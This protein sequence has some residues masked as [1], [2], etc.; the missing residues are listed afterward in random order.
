MVF[1][2]NRRRF[3]LGS[4]A[5]TAGCAIERDPT[6]PP[7]VIPEAL[8]ETPAGQPDAVT[9]SDDWWVNFNSPKLNALVER[10][11]LANLELRAAQSEARALYNSAL[12]VSGSSGIDS[13]ASLSLPVGT[14]ISTATAT[15]RATANVLPFREMSRARRR[16]WLQATSG[17]VEVER[18][19]DTSSVEV[20]RLAV[21]IDYLLRT[22]VVISNSVTN[23]RAAV[24]A[25][26]EQ[27]DRGDSTQLDV[28]RARARLSSVLAEDASNQSDLLTAGARLAASISGNINETLITD[29][30]SGTQISLPQ[31]G[32]GASINI[33][34]LTT[35]PSV[36]QREI[37]YLIRLS[38]LDSA[39]A[40][41][42]PSL[43]V[44]GQVTAST[45]T[46]GWIFSPSLTLPPLSST[47]R[48]ARTDGALD[49]VYAAMFSWQ[50]AV[51]EAATTVEVA[52]IQVQ[53]AWLRVAR[54]DAAARSLQRA[55]V[56]VQSL[57]N[58]GDVTILA[59]LETEQEY[60]DARISY[61]RSRRDLLTSYV[62]L[63]SSV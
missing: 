22:S 60:F 49:R 50:D 8:S 5:L 10:A 18:L 43:S 34:V 58:S 3:L 30:L 23:N 42:F 51:L 57:A 39:R 56:E 40:S 63:F 17:T 46:V 35:K 61:E 16:A 26:E 44:S 62:S 9:A 1:H 6:T 13:S 31:D 20:C 2:F 48:Q 37:T 32:D 4:V 14:S 47:R 52:Q 38:E 11:L 55:L 21:E 53:N 36:V 33:E 19:A 25:L 45:N 24:N 12:D 27:F 59:V 15:L 28:L 54:T 7:L 29:F 41:L